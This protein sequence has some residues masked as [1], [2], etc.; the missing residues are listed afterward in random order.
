MVGVLR[1]LLV[2]ERLIL[3]AGRGLPVGVALGD[4]NVLQDYCFFQ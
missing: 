3:V 4:R 2:I 1:I